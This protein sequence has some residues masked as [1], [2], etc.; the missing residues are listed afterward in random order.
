MKNH[1]NEMKRIAGSYRIGSLQIAS[2]WKK[3]ISDEKKHIAG[4]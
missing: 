1:L 2:I 4:G 3:R